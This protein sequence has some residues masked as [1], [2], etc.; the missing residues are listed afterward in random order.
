VNLPAFAVSAAV[1]WA[2]AVLQH[3]LAARLSVFGASPDLLLAAMAPIALLSRPAGA[4]WCGF[5]CG[6]AYGAVAG[7]NLA[8]YVVSRC[9]TAFGLSSANLLGI[10]FSVLAAGVLTALAT[11]CAQLLLLFLAPPA[12]IGA[13]LTA[14]IGSAM[15]N[16]VLAMPLYALLRRLFRPKSGLGA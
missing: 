10:E 7:A 13:F 2:A 12:S 9:L 11:I 4:L 3:G 16:G 15:Y 5:F 6:L 1:L 8:H 14:T